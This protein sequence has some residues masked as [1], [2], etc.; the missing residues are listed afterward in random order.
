[1]RVPVEY[2]KNFFGLIN[3][4]TPDNYYMGEEMNLTWMRKGI[5]WNKIQLE[6]GG[7]ID[8]SVY[9]EL[10]E[11]ARKHGITPMP[12]LAYTAEWASAAPAD[13]DRR[14][15][16]PIKEEYI[17]DWK[18]FVKQVMERYP[19]IEYFEIWNEPN[20][21]F[22]FHTDNDSN[23]REYVDRILIPAAE[24]IHEYGRKVVAPS[25]TVE[26]PFTTDKQGYSFDLASN[27]KG[28]NEWLNYHDAWKYTDI[29]SVHYIKGDTEKKEMPFADNMMPFYD[30]IYDNYIAT[31]K[32]EGLWNTEAGLTAT[33][34]SRDYGFQALEPW[35]REPYG[36]WVARYN[37]PVIHWA[38]ENGWE[39]KDQYKNFWYNL[40]FATEKMNVLRPTALM[41]K[42]D[43]DKPILSE[44]GQ[45]MKVLTTLMAD[46]EEVGNYAEQVDVGLGLHTPGLNYKF[47]NYA[48]SMD[49]DIFIAS[50]LDLPGLHLANDGSFLEA[51]IKGLNQDKD[52]EILMYNYLTGE[53]TRVENY[54]LNQNGDLEIKIPRISDP[55]LYFRVN[56]LS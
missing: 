1:M 37:I 53:E 17:S 38:L 30:Y 28:I 41:L 34:V 7:K 29:L 47:K 19:D 16:Y 23:H 39:F 46:A 8:F 43:N 9:D 51:T 55:I 20:I 49:D 36:Q 48:F 6:R 32:L 54:N 18:E 25:F 26:W 3:H 44:M 31:G 13:A 27:I 42:D 2:I 35:E 12:I 22:F 52:I 40:N 33:E 14:S 4:T 5:A 50:W 24:V 21:D 11:T 45:A 15:K 56:V 10:V